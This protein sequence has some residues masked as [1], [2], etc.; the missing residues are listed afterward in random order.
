MSAQI[1]AQWGMPYVTALPSMLQEPNR[2]ELRAAFLK[3][4]H[5]ETPMVRRAAA[6]VLAACNSRWREL[7]LSG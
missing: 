1:F 2:S 6:Q 5:D 7:W 3:L 4:C